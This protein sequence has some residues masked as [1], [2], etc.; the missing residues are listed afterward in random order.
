[1]RVMVRKKL[2]R[3]CNTS[4]AKQP[5]QVF[6]SVGAIPNELFMRTYKSVKFRT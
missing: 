2:R 1:M 3:R 5:T 4:V 6:C